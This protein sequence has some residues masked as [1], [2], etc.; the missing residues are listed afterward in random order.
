MPLGEAEGEELA[1]LEE[2]CAEYESADD[3][4][5]RIGERPLSVEFRSAW[6]TGPGE[7]EIEEFRIVLCCGGPH[8]ELR[9]DV[10]EHGSA[11]RVYFR[12]SWSGESGEY[13]GDDD[14]SSAAREFAEYFLQGI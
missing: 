10:G 6:T 5:D 13:W 2:T 4:R 3:A 11:S 9:G 1:E 8:V 14:E 7:M 12:Y